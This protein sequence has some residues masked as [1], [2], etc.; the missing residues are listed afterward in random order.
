[1]ARSVTEE[2]KEQEIQNVGDLQEGN[3]GVNNSESNDIADDF[4]LNGNIRPSG[5][6]KSG[7]IICHFFL[8]IQ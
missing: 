7:N 4:D 6:V 8:T 1:M 2:G 3:N 5:T